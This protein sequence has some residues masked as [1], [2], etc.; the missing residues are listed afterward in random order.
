MLS[1]NRCGN[2][3]DRPHRRI[4]TTWCSSGGWPSPDA[5]CACPLSTD[6][7]VGAAIVAVLTATYADD[8]Q[9]QRHP[10]TPGAS[11]DHIRGALLPE[12]RTSTVR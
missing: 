2:E 3:G 4:R 11:P 9:P 1:E 5:Q 8:E 12:D 6:V 7:S 10:L